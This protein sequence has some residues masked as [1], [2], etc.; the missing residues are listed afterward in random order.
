MIRKILTILLL[1]SLLALSMLLAL[2]AWIVAPMLIHADS[3]G[4]ERLRASAV[5][6]SIQAGLETFMRDVGRYP[7]PTEGLSAILAP[8]TAIVGKWNGPY[9]EDQ[10]REL[11]DPWG[12]LIEYR[13]PGKFN[14]IYYDLWS[15]GPNGIDEHETPDSDDV[16][17]WR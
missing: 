7:T 12:E 1:V 4:M 13:Y 16:K 8:P 3:A 11:R 5:I 17:N 6:A 10:F 9:V 14:R 2:F 15:K